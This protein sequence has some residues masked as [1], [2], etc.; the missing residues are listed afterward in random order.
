MTNTQNGVTNLIQI[1]LSEAWKQRFTV[2]EY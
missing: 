2:Q 1:T